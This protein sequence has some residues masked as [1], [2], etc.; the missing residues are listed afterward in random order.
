[1]NCKIS[2]VFLFDVYIQFHCNLR[3]DY[4]WMSRSDFVKTLEDDTVSNCYDKLVRH[5]RDCY[6][7]ICD[8]SKNFRQDKYFRQQHRNR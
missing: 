8:S 2:D 6:T 3:A 5:K 7:S 1:M 4:A